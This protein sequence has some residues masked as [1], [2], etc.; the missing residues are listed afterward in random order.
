MLDLLHI[1]R[2]SRAREGLLAVALILTLVAGAALAACGGGDGSGLPRSPQTPTTKL[3]DN[4]PTCTERTLGGQRV[5]YAELAGDCDTLLAI[6]STL[7]GMGMIS[8]N[9]EVPIAEWQGVVVAGVPPRVT[10]L[11]LNSLGLTGIFP[12]QLG[13]LTGL[14]Q[15]HLYENRLT[16][17]LPT[18][19]GN[20][21]E[22]TALFL[23]DNRLGGSLPTQ[24][25][26]LSKLTNLCLD[27]N[28]LT[29]SIPVQ[30]T[31]LPA[32]TE[33]CLSGNSLGGI[34]PPEMERLT[35]LSL[36]RLAGNMFTGC[37]PGALRNVANH[38]LDTL[39][40]PDC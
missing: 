25:S 10:E 38:D 6:R 31:T 5:N 1:M 35:T 27:R 3:P 28:A 26:N 20:L 36:L 11:Y 22:L 24:L 23:Y 40:L 2:V 12:T 39:N 14:V 30:L 8:W 9:P 21:T 19:L 4:P 18:Q 13:N 34:I 15:M 17:A 7:A 37:V 29:G 32:L 16:G 33:L